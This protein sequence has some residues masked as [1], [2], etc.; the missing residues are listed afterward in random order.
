[1]KAA[2]IDDEAAELPADWRVLA[3][4]PLVVPGLNAARHLVVVARTA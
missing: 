3:V 2:R 1:M 4:H